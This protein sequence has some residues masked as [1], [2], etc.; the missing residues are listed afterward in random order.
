MENNKKGLFITFEGIDGCGKTTQI[1]LLEK[2][3]NSKNYKTIVTLEPGS[4]QIG[5]KL[6]Q[7]LLHHEGFVS[8]RAELF[9]YL[10]DRAQH[11]EEIVMP[12]INNGK[13]VLC[14]RHTDSTLAYQGY[15]RGGNIEQLQILNSIA[16]SD[17]KP[18]ITFLFDIDIQTAQ[19]RLGAIK[20]R[21]EASGYDFYQKVRNGYLSLSKKF[22]ERIKVIDASLTPEDVSEQVKTIIDTVL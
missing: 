9:M 5:K 10:A 21:L 8:D 1:E 11:I 3:L 7:I 4:T 16:T 17:L 18:D 12:N 15:A 14:D 13:I 20:D 22:P 2:Y 19:K 6:R